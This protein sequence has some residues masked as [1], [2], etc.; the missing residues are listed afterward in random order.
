MAPAPG[1]RR[2]K[3]WVSM[4]S[5]ALA[6]CSGS[7]GGVRPREAEA[8]PAP[9]P[10]AGAPAPASPR[11]TMAARSEAS[12]APRVLAT[13]GDAPAPSPA[14]SEAPAP[15]PSPSPAAAI[16][17]RGRN[18]D[19]LLNAM[20][21]APVVKVLRKISRKAPIYQLD[22]GNGL[23]I[24]FKPQTYERP[25]LW[26][27]DVLAWELGRLLGIHDRVPP[28]TARLVSHDLL[29]DPTE[30]LVHSK[31]TPGLALGSAAFWMPV[32][33]DTHLTGKAGQDRWGRWLGI[34][35][36]IPTDPATASLAE[37]VSTLVVFDYL[38][39]NTDRFRNSENLMAD[40][41]GRIVF[42]DNNEGWKAAQLGDLST[43]TSLLR[44]VHRF[45]R[46]LVDNLRKADTPAFQ[47]RLQPWIDAGRPLFDQQRLDL[48]E[49]RRVFLLSYIDQLVKTY[50][51]AAVLPWP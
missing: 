23:E 22:L 3:L 31:T 40:E 49:R 2:S 45:S 10:G 25:V 30:V 16:T 18:V 34:Q 36:A 12:P 27:N 24:A 8:D 33:I 20:A 14:P 41:H 13:P 51:E 32:L 48:F 37:Q 5:A 46:S 7:R 29:K 19:E 39:A 35:F 21:T 17:F 9:G 47:A 50:G 43:N 6:S 44:N 28:V 42:R 4:L 1:W 15:A 38:Q 26:R 11:P